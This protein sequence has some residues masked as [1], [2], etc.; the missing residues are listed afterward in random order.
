MIHEQDTD[1]RVEPLSTEPVTAELA[2]RKATQSSASANPKA[3]RL[4][5]RQSPHG[6]V[7]HLVTFPEIGEPPILPP[8]H[9]TV[10]ANPHA[11]IAGLANGSNLVVRQSLPCVE[12]DDRA[13]TQGVQSA[14]LSAKPHVALSVFTQTGNSALVNAAFGLEDMPL[15]LSLTVANQCAFG[16][17]PRSTGIIDIMFLSDVQAQRPPPATT[18]DCNRR[19]QIPPNRPPAR[20]GGG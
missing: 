7:D 8:T 20:R 6:V 17:D 18:G 10:G 4:I 5:F 1:L 9:A 13:R 2:R 16:S 19:A 12:S 3:T 11:A 14:T 15:K